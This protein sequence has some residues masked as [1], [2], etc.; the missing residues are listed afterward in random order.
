M[1]KLFKGAT[2]GSEEIVEE[3]MDVSA[4]EIEEDKKHSVTEVLKNKKTKIGLGIAGGIAIIG[5]IVLAMAKKN[6]ASE[7]SD[8]DETEYLV[9]TE[10]ETEE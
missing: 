5:G 6:S 9:E 2:E 1:A 10:A 8:E 7:S 3:T 4:E